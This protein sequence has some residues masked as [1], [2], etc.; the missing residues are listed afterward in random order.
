MAFRF[1]DF[2]VTSWRGD[3]IL[4]KGLWAEKG[5]IAEEFKPEFPNAN[6]HNFKNE[7]IVYKESLAVQKWHELG[8]IDDPMQA[9]IEGNEDLPEPVKSEISEPCDLFIAKTPFK[10]TLT[11]TFFKKI[12]TIIDT[13]ALSKNL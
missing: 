13:T 2:M 8:E 3:K 10:R 5:E 4:L 1:S 9:V 11:T 12:D 7:E 6:G